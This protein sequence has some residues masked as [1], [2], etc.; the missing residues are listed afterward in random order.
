MYLKAPCLNCLN[1]T[2]TCHSTCK[3]YI[4]FKKENDRIREEK[5]KINILT[6]DLYGISEQKFKKI[7][8]RR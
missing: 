2:I 3:L 1:R 7:N 5:H 6:Q 4:D 8:K